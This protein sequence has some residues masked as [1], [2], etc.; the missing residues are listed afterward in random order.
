MLV[1]VAGGCL[2]RSRVEYLVSEKIST[3]KQSKVELWKDSS[4]V[5]P[6][7]FRN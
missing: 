6:Y 4:S 1:V 7:L 2:V 5:K 3:L